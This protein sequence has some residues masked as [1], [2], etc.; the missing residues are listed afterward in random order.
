MQNSPDVSS[1]VSSSTGIKRRSRQPNNQSAQ[2][3]VSHGTAPRRI[4]LQ[5]NLQVGSN[6]GCLTKNLSIPDKNTEVPMVLEVSKLSHSRPILFAY[7]LNPNCDFERHLIVMYRTMMI[8]ICKVLLLMQLQ[9][10][11][12]QQMRRWRT[13]MR[14]EKFLKKNRV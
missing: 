11:H 10:M 3:N 9:M 4:R 6:Y 12:L 8:P 5:K 7:H 1:A 2:N 13:S 14:M